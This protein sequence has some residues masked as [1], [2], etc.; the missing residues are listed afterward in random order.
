MANRA[1]RTA[2]TFGA[3]LALAFLVALAPADAHGQAAERPL[4]VDARAGIAVPIGDLGDV[5]DVGPT[6]GVGV[7]YRLQPRLSV[8]ADADVDLYGGADFE[9][10]SATQSSA[11]DMSLWHLAAGLEFDVTRPGT[12]RWHVTALGGIGATAIDTDPFVE[13][14]V[15]NQET[16]RTEIDFD[17]TYFTADGGL[18]MGYDV[19]DRVDVYGSIL[20]RLSFADE[21]ATAVFSALSPTEVNAF[22][23]ASSVPVTVGARIAF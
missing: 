18:R 17:A 8:R 5:A 23:M 10:T 22:D 4:S 15:D 6:V 19:H 12:S 20:W 14:P 13:G 2:R 9:A 16:G 1:A 21:E 11:P 3:A 7:A